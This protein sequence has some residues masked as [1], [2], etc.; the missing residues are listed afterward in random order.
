MAHKHLRIIEILKDED[1]MTRTPRIRAVCEEMKPRKFNIN[2]S[3]QDAHVLSDFEKHIGGIAMIPTREGTLK[4]GTPFISYDHDAEF[5]SVE[6][7]AKPAFI[8]PV[9]KTG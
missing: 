7:P 4:D 1:P 5:I 2:L 8:L 3:K 6:K 9:Q